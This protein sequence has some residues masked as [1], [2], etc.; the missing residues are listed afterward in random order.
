MVKPIGKPQQNDFFPFKKGKSRQSL[1]EEKKRLFDRNLSHS[2]EF[3]APKD[4]GQ[5]FKG[6]GEN[7]KISKKIGKEQV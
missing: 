1:T 5:T 2:D 4:D 3:Q 7:R 6:D